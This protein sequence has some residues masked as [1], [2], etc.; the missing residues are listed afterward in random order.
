MKFTL[1]IL[2]SCFINTLSTLGAQDLD[3]NIIEKYVEG[4]LNKEESI[5]FALHTSVNYEQ[6]MNQLEA[7]QNTKAQSL[8]TEKLQQVIKKLKEVGEVSKKSE[9]PERSLTGMHIAW[10]IVSKDDT[11]S[12]LP[13]IYKVDQSSAAY[14]AG[15]RA[16][17][18]I[19]KAHGKNLT[20]SHSAIEFRRLLALWPTDSSLKLSILRSPTTVG[21][22][23]SG[24]DRRKRMTFEFTP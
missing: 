4:T 1:F 3:V 13:L 7:L 14:K 24:R 19:Q 8:S 6:V 15:L 20:G 5:E 9:K 12:S 21:N 16:G 17:D 10:F 18:V 2:V 22:G 11:L 23:F